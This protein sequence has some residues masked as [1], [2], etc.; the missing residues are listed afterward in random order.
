MI[1]LQHF[2]WETVGFSCF[3]NDGRLL[4]RGAQGQRHAYQG[5]EEKRALLVLQLSSMHLAGIALPLNE[6]QLC[7]LSSK[8]DSGH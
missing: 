4:Q 1:G 3:E 8:E 6:H 2:L 5:D 7:K